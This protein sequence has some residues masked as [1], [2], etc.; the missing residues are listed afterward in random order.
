MTCGT[1][2]QSETQRLGA[3]GP[4]AL[5]SPAEIYPDGRCARGQIE[6]FAQNN[7]KVP[8]VLRAAT[9]EAGHTDSGSAEITHRRA[10]QPDTLRASASDNSYASAS[11]AGG[12]HRHGAPIPNHSA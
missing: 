3:A 11:T 1:A 4:R 10:G 7:L 5:E 2:V 12:H 8:Q 9:E 6:T